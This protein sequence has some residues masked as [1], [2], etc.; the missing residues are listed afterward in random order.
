MME[1]H[2]IKNYILIVFMI[3]VNHV[4]FILLILFIDLILM[5]PGE[6]RNQHNLMIF[7]MISSSGQE[8]L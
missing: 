3:V 6:I 1:P 7:I 2:M 8:V 4:G 5:T